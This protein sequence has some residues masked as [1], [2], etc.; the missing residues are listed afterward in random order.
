M[1]W[2]FVWL[3]VMILAITLLWWKAI[4]NKER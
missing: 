3:G 1:I 2:G 4:G